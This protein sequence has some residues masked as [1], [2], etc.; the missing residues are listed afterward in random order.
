MVTA[1]QRIQRIQILDSFGG[2]QTFRSLRAVSTIAFHIDC[3]IAVAARQARQPSW[4]PQESVWTF[5]SSPWV[6]R[7]SE[8]WSNV[9]RPSATESTIHARPW[10]LW[11]VSMRMATGPKFIK[12]H[13]IQT[14]AEQI[15]VR[16]QH[17]SEPPGRMSSWAIYRFQCNTQFHRSCRKAQS[18]LLKVTSKWK[19]P[20]GSQPC[21]MRPNAW[22]PVVVK[23]CRSE[24]ER[25]RAG[26]CGCGRICRSLRWILKEPKGLRDSF[27]K[28]RNLSWSSYE[29]S[30]LGLQHLWKHEACLQKV[31]VMLLKKCSLPFKLFCLSS[32]AYRIPVEKPQYSINIQTHMQYSIFESFKGTCLIQRQRFL[33]EK[34]WSS[35]ETTQISY[36]KQSLDFCAGL[37]PAIL[38]I[39]VIKVFI[40]LYLMQI[41]YRCI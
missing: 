19:C 32:R 11:K 24:T 25:G 16:N 9:L 34:L 6:F 30:L 8:V 22:H 40:Q 26:C 41:A 18:Q 4:N 5:P 28:W 14:V 35:F 20:M 17:H 29:S 12:I 37:A 15:H 1:H 33:I 2:F 10:E 39:L 38:L 36:K 21:G 3:M 31:S 7:I 23:D 13:T 27:P